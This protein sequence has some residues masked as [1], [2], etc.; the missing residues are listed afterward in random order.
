MLAHAA[1]DEQGRKARRVVGNYPK[2]QVNES[3]IEEKRKWEEYKLLEDGAS[4]GGNVQKVIH[5]T[6]QVFTL[7]PN[8]LFTNLCVQ[9]FAVK[10]LT[11]QPKMRQELEI[12]ELVAKKKHP[13][14][15]HLQDF[16]NGECISCIVM[17]LCEGNL[18]GLRE[19][20]QGPFPRRLLYEVLMQ[21][22]RGVEYL[23][24]IPICH[25][26]LKPENS[27]YSPQLIIWNLISLYSPVY[28]GWRQPSFQNR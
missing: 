17:E 2:H 20:N 28:V 21:I 3:L 7:I 6:G 12:F 16:W 25:R 23:H 14:I 8:D 1:V 5:T 15:V 9:Y 11:D 19:S 18:A 4:L 13:N 26:D 22:T 24:N 27:I 10:I